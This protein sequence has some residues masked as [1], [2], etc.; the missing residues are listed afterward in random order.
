[1]LRPSV[2]AA[3][4]SISRFS[5]KARVRDA[6]LRTCRHPKPLRFGWGCVRVGWP[7]QTIWRLRAAIK[8]ARREAIPVTP[9][10][11]SGQAGALSQEAQ[12]WTPSFRMQADTAP[13]EARRT[14]ARRTSPLQTPLPSRVSRGGPLQ[15]VGTHVLVFPEGVQ[16]PPQEGRQSQFTTSTY[17]RPLRHPLRHPNG[18]GAARLRVAVAPG[19]MQTQAATECG[20][21]LTTT[22]TSP[23]FRHGMPI[24]DL[25]RGRASCLRGATTCCDPVMRRTRA[26]ISVYTPS[27]A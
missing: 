27:A 1:M 2:V 21:C 4:S 11:A 6:L 25:Q 23:S 7:L 14:E 16:P 8:L 22:T 12:R 26:A 13:S 15:G 19:G 17:S 10:R 3:A 20:A 24:P 18:P 5:C 9:G